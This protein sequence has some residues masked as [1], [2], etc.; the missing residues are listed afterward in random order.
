MESP[1]ANAQFGVQL[2]D[3]PSSSEEL[4]GVRE[5]RGAVAVGEADAV[6]KAVHCVHN[7]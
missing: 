4:R 5:P 7:S 1:D 3:V 6:D 2:T